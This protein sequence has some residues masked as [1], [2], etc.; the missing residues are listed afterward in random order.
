MSTGCALRDPVR[1]R[2]ATSPHLYSFLLL[3]LLL[4]LILILSSSPRR[5][6][7]LPVHQKNVGEVLAGLYGAFWGPV[8]LCRGPLGVRL[9]HRILRYLRNPKYLGVPGP[10]GPRHGPSRGPRVAV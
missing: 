1:R 4:L 2:L 3:L 5:S 8:W 10:A 9:G 7:L 6:P